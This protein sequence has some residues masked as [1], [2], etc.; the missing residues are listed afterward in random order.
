M[1]GA[2]LDAQAVVDV[3]EDE[4]RDWF[5]SLRDHPERYE[6]EAHGGFEFVEGSFGQPGAR[7]RTRER[8][9]FLRLELLFEL[10]E[11]RQ[12][13][14]WFRLARPSSMGV[15]GRFRLHGVDPGT[16]TLSLAIKAETRI[17]QLM[18]R[19]YPVAAAIHQQIQREVRHIR[20]SMENV[21]GD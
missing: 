9:C 8:F 3:S 19:C 6:F 14:F 13:E 4:A 15:H 17:G 7:F 10:T 21:Y 12:T 16:T 2:I 18:L 20:S 5:L 11:V 1:H